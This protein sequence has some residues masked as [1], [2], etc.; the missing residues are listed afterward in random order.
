[1]DR[2]SVQLNSTFRGLWRVIIIDILIHGG[3]EMDKEK[4]G[5]LILKLRKEKEMTQKDLAEALYVSDKTISKW[6]CGQG[7]PDVSLLPQL[8]QIFS[9]DVEGI[10]LGD[11]NPRD[12]DGGNMKQTKFYMCEDCGNIITSTGCGDISC[13]GRKLEGL[14]AQKPDE[15][16]TINLE[17][18]EN[19]YYVSFSHEMKKNHFISFM[20]YVTC[21]SVFLMKL[22]PEQSGEVRFPKLYGGKLYY[23]CTRHGLWVKE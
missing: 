19:D 21:N 9:V 3:G 11:L 5:Q 18:I 2:F 15:A 1:M 4:V 8:A 13:C 10:L 6:E 16:H 23:G 14:V 22:Y 17:E 12:P 20:A 7:C